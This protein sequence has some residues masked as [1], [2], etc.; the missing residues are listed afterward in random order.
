MYMD[1]TSAT[2]QNNETAYSYFSKAAAAVFIH[3]SY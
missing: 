1:G 3:I 2:K